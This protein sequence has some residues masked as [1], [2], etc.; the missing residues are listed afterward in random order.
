[1]ELIPRLWC[2][3]AAGPIAS[4]GSPSD[5][6]AASTGDAAQTTA[7][8][9]PDSSSTNLSSGTALILQRTTPRKL[10]ASLPQPPHD[11]KYTRAIGRSHQL[12]S[13][14]LVRPAD[15]LALLKRHGEPFMI[16]TSIGPC[17]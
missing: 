1:M 2:D 12:A 7:T 10:A 8:T 9:G 3:D 6:A 11:Q 13:A 17:Q 15:Q 16:Q 4:G 5:Q 14:P